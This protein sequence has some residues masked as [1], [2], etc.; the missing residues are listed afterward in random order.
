MQEGFSC[1][2][3]SE[4]GKAF[5]V[6]GDYRADCVFRRRLFVA[7]LMLASTVKSYHS[8]QIIFRSVSGYFNAAFLFITAPQ[9]SAWRMASIVWLEDY[10]RNPCNHYSC[11][12]TN[13]RAFLASFPTVIGK[14]SLLLMSRSYGLYVLALYLLDF[15][16][17]FGTLSPCFSLRWL[18]RASVNT[19]HSHA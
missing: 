6:F 13:S 17:C 18:S 5:H 10:H 7:S 2:L 11:E 16:H 19:R 1:L 12:F 9:K 3:K 8:E 15:C 14:A 4:S